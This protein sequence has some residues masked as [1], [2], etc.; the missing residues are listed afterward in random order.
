MVNST[1][2]SSLIDIAAYS[3]ARSVGCALLDA[4]ARSRLLLP[5]PSF[6]S[7][8]KLPDGAGRS[9]ALRHSEHVKTKDTTAKS[10]R[11]IRPATADSLATRQSMFRYKGATLGSP[12]V[13]AWTRRSSRRSRQPSDRLLRVSVSGIDGSWASGNTN[14]PPVFLSRYE[15]SKPG[16]GFPPS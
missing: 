2:S 14:T 15:R 7:S 4:M 1:S 8:M 5:L 16:G 11:S 13:D 3:S 9:M 12:H 10:D 6:S